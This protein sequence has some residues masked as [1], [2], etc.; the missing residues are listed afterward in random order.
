[1]NLTV[2]SL[3]LPFAPVS[4][5]ARVGTESPVCEF[6]VIAVTR[7]VC[8]LALFFPFYLSS[9]LIVILSLSSYLSLPSSR[10]IAVCRMSR[11]AVEVRGRARELMSTS[12]SLLCW[13]NPD[14]PSLL[15]LSVLSLSLSPL[16]FSL[17][18]SLRFPSNSPPC[19]SLEFLFSQIQN[20]GSGNLNF[21]RKLPNLS[22]WGTR[23]AQEVG[24]SPPIRKQQNS[25]A[26]S[27]LATKIGRAHV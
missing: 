19:V 1:M 27:S 25:Q 15:Y 20:F 9:S 16:S 23:L 26:A 18:A 4:E 7:P 2:A 10:V 24:G 21:N 11:W 3:S 5:S 17:S 13:H 8:S 22:A 12:L 14:T 6:P